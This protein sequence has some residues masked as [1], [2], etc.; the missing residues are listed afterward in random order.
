M[1]SKSITKQID[2][3]KINLITYQVHLKF[4]CLKTFKTVCVMNNA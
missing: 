1:N 2:V 3:K 4:Y